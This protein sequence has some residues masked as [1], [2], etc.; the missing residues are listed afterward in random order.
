MLC[1]IVSVPL[2]AQT[3]LYVPT[4]QTRC[5]ASATNATPIVISTAGCD[6][7]SLAAATPALVAHG[8]TNGTVIVLAGVEGNTAANG[9]R[10]ATNVTETTA[11]L[12][13]LAGAPVAGN[14]E[15]L[16]YTGGQGTSYPEAAAGSLV[17][18]KD[19]PR[20]WLDGPGGA[21]TS[22]LCTHGRRDCKAVS[23]NPAYAAMKT[24]IDGRVLTADTA[25][26]SEMLIAQLQNG[27]FG[28]LGGAA[29]M[30][31][32]TGNTAYRDKA[33]AALNNIDKYAKGFGCLTEQISACGDSI[34][35]DYGSKY[36]W[37]IAQAYSIVRSGMTSGERTVFVN[38]MLTD[39]DDGCTSRF[40]AGTG[41][42]NYTLYA[43]TI[44]GN[45]TQWLTNADTT[46][47]IATGDSI[48][49]TAGCT[50]G[51]CVGMTMIVKSV[52]SD[53][54]LTIQGSPTG[55]FLATSATD[56]PFWIGK[57][58]TTGNCGFVNFINYSG[59][60]PIASGKAHGNSYL[61]GAASS[62]G[63]ATI[64]SRDES[65]RNEL[66]NQNITKGLGFLALAIAL[67]D[68]DP[69]AQAMLQRLVF[70][71]KDFWYPLQKQWTTGAM[72]I[73]A[74]YYA[75]RV[76][77][78]T[79]DFA[80]QLRNS[81]YEPSMDFTGGTWLKTPLSLWVYGYSRA[82]NRSIRWGGPA[83]VA[84]TADHWKGGLA[85]AYL[86]PG[87]DESKAWL[88]ILKNYTGYYLPAETQFGYANMLGYPDNYLYSD[89]TAPTA[90]PNTTLPL[91]RNLTVSDSQPNGEGTGLVI[92][93][94][95]WLA[96]SSIFEIHALS[97]F[98]F[99][100]LYGTSYSGDPASYK[101]F[102]RHYLLAE[103]YGRGIQPTFTAYGAPNEQSNFMRI[104]PYLSNSP[105]LLQRANFKS[106]IQFVRTSRFWN[107][108]SN[109][110]TYA[111]VD[112]AGAYQAAAQITF[113]HRHFA[114]FKKLGRSEYIIAADAVRTSGGQQK[115]TY[116][117][118]P[119][120]GQSGVFENG[121]T[122]WPANGAEGNTVLTDDSLVSSGPASRILTKVLKPGGATS[123]R[124]YTDNP[125]GSYTGTVDP[126]KGPL[127]G[128]GQTFRV[129]ICASADGVTCDASNLKTNVLV[130]HRVVDGTTETANPV[131][132]LSAIDPNFIG[133]QVDDGANSI[134]AVFPAEGITLSAAA[135]TTTHSDAGQYLVSGL[136]AGLWSISRDGAVITAAAN[137]DSSGTLYWEGG[138]GAY[139]LIRT[140]AGPLSVATGSLPP[141]LLNGS[142]FFPLVALGGTPPYQWSVTSGR[143]PD[144]V[145][146]SPAG[147][148]S[149]TATLSGDFAFTVSV[150]D[151][152][153][154]SVTKDLML[155]VGTTPLR[156]LT[157]V[158]GGG[159][160]G[161]PYQAS[162]L[163]GGGV[164][165]YAWTTVSG[166]LCGGLSLVSDGIIS[167]QPLQV[168]TCAFRVRVTDQGGLSAE[169]DLEL[170]VVA[171]NSLSI[172]TT[173]LPDGKSG[174]DYM[175]QL[176]GSG[177]VTPLQWSISAGNLPDGLQLDED[178]GIISGIPASAG[179][180][181]FT[182]QLTDSST[183]S[184]QVAQDLSITVTPDVPELALVS[185]ELPVVQAGSDCRTA[186]QALG[187]VPPHQFQATRQSLPTGM[188]LSAAGLLN[189]RP[190]AAGVPRLELADAT[191]GSLLL[192]YGGAGLRWAA[193]GPGLGLT[194][195][196]LYYA[197]V[198]C[199]GAAAALAAATRSAGRAG[200]GAA[201]LAVK[202][203][204]GVDK[205]R[206]DYG[207]TAALG[208]RLET[209]CVA[210]RCGASI[211]AVSG[212]PLCHQSAYL[213]GSQ[214]VRVSKPAVL[215]A[216]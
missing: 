161:R 133:A 215:L 205:L 79:A 72:Q 171:E 201:K 182:A 209:T 98:R 51:Y 167:G 71:W 88:H 212:Q 132:L 49:W 52:E 184:L 162:L 178:T 173:S 21:L 94:T 4:G 143:L 131:A 174:S 180:W 135:F 157:S 23:S 65:S 183:P 107:D 55:G 208:A 20:V 163:V 89:P 136:T 113:A 33:I 120:N 204:A 25:A 59:Y 104:G 38:K 214:V 150:D 3:T 80:I 216:R 74:K 24:A 181:A 17:T 114:H 134:V 81:F 125:D 60:S 96:D 36:M 18:L 127:G 45:G 32:S 129:S 95:G 144:G 46:Q 8:W 193:F 191:E 50:S 210:G 100:S 194:L 199:G 149:G 70:W 61:S 154:Q 90:D 177:G 64:Y 159:V 9:T 166:T 87:S 138:A 197:R 192:R 34:T 156:I 48:G 28:Y 12:Y 10:V 139:V 213:S 140:G 93:R 68:D 85:S 109:A 196:R 190:A 145:S 19:H 121:S 152:D 22:T 115:V 175:V 124:V 92:S 44:T 151:S 11:E 165:P 91:S 43:K 40:Y 203:P 47:R 6:N 54:S 83:P 142:Y 146:L 76:Q 119:N 1:W 63:G 108:P 110:A 176:T 75:T 170:S 73:T 105:S 153:G 111:M 122:P 31:Q 13:D 189:G 2:L 202:A 84:M 186:I 169:R 30:Y 29:L 126:A 97:E 86:T 147:L 195:N 56:G 78:F 128:V 14:G 112:Y 66:Y 37:N 158:L 41:T 160:V 179:Q 39:V 5:V 102:K 123:L 200:T 26:P 155:T 164:P 148:L 141:A 168:E 67:A 82:D 172:L 206:V 27:D 188:T 185:Q 137:V 69:R 198:S 35:L 130:A 57:P 15:F 207:G 116:L 187:G 117:H 16:R 77:P 99:S 62:F 103:D 211:P 118:Y 101:I 42:V 7:T 106:Q 53:T 58:W